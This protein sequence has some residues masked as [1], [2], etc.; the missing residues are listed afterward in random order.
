MKST[1]LY[2]QFRPRALGTILWG[3][4]VCGVLDL[5]AAFV[6]W[7]LRIRIPQTIASG[8]LGPRSFQYGAWSGA[9]GVMLHFVIAFGAATVFYVI[10]RKLTFLVRR[11]VLA[12]IFWGTTVYFVMGWVVVPLSRVPKGPNAPFSWTQFLIGL[13]THWLCV[14][15]PITIAA[16]LSVREHAG[17]RQIGRAA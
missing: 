5:T 13:G 9:L 6:H 10:S 8:V 14:G 7:G 4:L 11:F 2:S 3:G 12:G 15:L 16:R 17:E 1:A